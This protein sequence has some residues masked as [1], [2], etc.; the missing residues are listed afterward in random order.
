MGAVYCNFLFTLSAINDKNAVAT[1][2]WSNFVIRLFQ[3]PANIINIVVAIFFLFTVFLGPVALAIVAYSLLCLVPSA[4][5]GLGLML[6]AVKKRLSFT[7][8]CHSP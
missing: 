7:K 1:L 3:L 6:S 2:S 5:I 8:A 4:I